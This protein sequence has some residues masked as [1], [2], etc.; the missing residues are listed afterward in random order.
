MNNVLKKNAW[1]PATAT[2]GIDATRLGKW[3]IKRT[4]REKCWVGRL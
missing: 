2:K 4:F 3:K 1:Q